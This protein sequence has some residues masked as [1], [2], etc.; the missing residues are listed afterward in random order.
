MTTIG[1]VLFLLFYALV[2][3]GARKSKKRLFPGDCQECKT[4]YEGDMEFSYVERNGERR[5]VCPKCAESSAWEIKEARR[6]ERLKFLELFKLFE[7]PNI[8]IDME[9]VEQAR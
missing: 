8:E 4:L 6:L 2:V 3:S 7:H 5:R 1:V 9:L